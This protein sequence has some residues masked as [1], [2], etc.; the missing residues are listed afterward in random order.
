MAAGGLLGM[1]LL[2]ISKCHPKSTV[3]K[4]GKGVNDGG[5]EKGA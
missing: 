3:F 5:H 2:C 1:K 4:H